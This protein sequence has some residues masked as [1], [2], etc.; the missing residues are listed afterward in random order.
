M[1]M[2]ILVLLKT[3]LYAKSLK[4]FK[5]TNLLEWK[6][7]FFLNSYFWYERQ[8]EGKNSEAEKYSL[9]YFC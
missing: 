1:L 7:R 9:F 5:L 6:A 8:N 3:Y 2:P 4:S